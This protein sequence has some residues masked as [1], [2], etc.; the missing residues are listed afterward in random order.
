[1]I[2][3]LIKPMKAIMSKINDLL[4]DIL[5]HNSNGLSAFRLS[6]LTFSMVI[7]AS[8]TIFAQDKEKVYM[9][10]NYVKNSD[11]ARHLQAKVSWKDGK[12]KVPLI[13]LKIDIYLDEVADSLKLGTIVSDHEG[14]ASFLLTEST[15]AKRAGNSKFIGR[16]QEN[17]YFKVREKSVDIT[18][19]TIELDLYEKDSVKY[20]KAKILQ[21]D[22]ETGEMV[23]VSDIDVKFYIQRMFSLLPFGGEYTSTD[24]NGEAT[25]E[26]PNYIPKDIDGSIT[27]FAKLEDTDEYGTIETKEMMNW[28]APQHVDHSFYERSLWAQRDKAPIWLIFMANFTILT[29][30]GALIYIC[31]IVLKI[32]KSGKLST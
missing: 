19:A 7:L 17:K 25:V 30:W 18:E 4:Q 2:C 31:L 13:G 6:V 22:S 27:V 23:P 20:V 10:F 5:S 16:I 9:Q 21:A 26:F 28:G 15:L 1:M 32:W 3:Y 24:E 11:N 12:K 14:R 8:G 29:V